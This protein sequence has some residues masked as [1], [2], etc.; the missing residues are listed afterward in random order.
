MD[1]NNGILEEKN[2]CGEE[3]LKGFWR[4]ASQRPYLEGDVSCMGDVKG[5]WGGGGLCAEFGDE[6][7]GRYVLIF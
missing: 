4:M 2:G 7:A 5:K 6:L 3:P 1:G